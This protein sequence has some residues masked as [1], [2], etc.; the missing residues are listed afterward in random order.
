MD[1]VTKTYD[2]DGTRLTNCC[3]AYSTYM[4]VDYDASTDE[5]V[6]DL[7]CKEC[8]GIVEFGEGDRSETWNDA[9]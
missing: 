6:F 9:L 5:A 4:E 3:G 1:T 8:C 7:C 2:M